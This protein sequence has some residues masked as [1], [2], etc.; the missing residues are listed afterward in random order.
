MRLAADQE[1]L[2][3]ITKKMWSVAIYVVFLGVWKK[4]EVVQEEAREEP[5]GTPTWYDLKEVSP[6]FVRIGCELVNLA[7]L[8]RYTALKEREAFKQLGGIDAV[9]VYSHL[10]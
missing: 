4:V 1:M 6:W 10:F 3:I 8:Q 9:T 7:S 2:H 5:A